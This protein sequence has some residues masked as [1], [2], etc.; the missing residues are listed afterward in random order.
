MSLVLRRN[1]ENSSADLGAESANVDN[2]ENV[3][4]RCHSSRYVEASEIVALNIL[5]WP[6]YSFDLFSLRWLALIRSAM[7]SRIR[8][9]IVA[10]SGASQLDAWCGR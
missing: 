2:G 1:A 5:R 6:W 9:C 8:A 3:L 7:V 4:Q 10:D